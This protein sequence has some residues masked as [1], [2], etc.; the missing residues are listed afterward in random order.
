MKLRTLLNLSLVA[1]LILP[2]Y[3]LFA[4]TSCGA[5]PLP[6]PATQESTPE[7]DI[8]THRVEQA[9]TKL[10]QAEAAVERC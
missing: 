7:L 10:E 2:A 3:G 5:E 9:K 1:G 8:S 4:A 6:T